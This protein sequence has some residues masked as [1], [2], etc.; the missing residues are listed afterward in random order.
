MAEGQRF[1]RPGPVDRRGS[2]CSEGAA[3]GSDQ[4]LLGGGRGVQIRS[5]SGMWTFGAVGAARIGRRTRARVR[6]RAGNLIH[7]QGSTLRV[8]L[9]HIVRIAGERRLN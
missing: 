2:I 4:P 1:R 8:K 3:Y 6:E 7:A 9:R 5:N